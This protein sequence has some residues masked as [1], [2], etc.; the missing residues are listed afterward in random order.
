MCDSKG[1]RSSRGINLETGVGAL[2]RQSPYLSVR[3]TVGRKCVLK[4]TMTVRKITKKHGTVS[5]CIWAVSGMMHDL[6]A[7]ERVGVGVVQMSCRCGRGSSISRLWCLKQ[8]G[9]SWT[10]PSV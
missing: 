5:V 10:Q 4:T 6:E 8:R 2:C 7:S 1:V 3:P 9:I